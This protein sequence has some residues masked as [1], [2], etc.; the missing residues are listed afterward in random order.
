MK[1]RRGIGMPNDVGDNHAQ[2]AA[3]THLHPKFWHSNTVR[4]LAG[5]LTPRSADVTSAAHAVCTTP[6]RP[7]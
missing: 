7:A 4:L 2:V 6:E 1:C 5:G 3:S